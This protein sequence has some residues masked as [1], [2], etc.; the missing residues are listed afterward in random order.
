MTINI[1]L[2]IEDLFIIQIRFF[3]DFLWRIFLTAFSFIDI[4][5]VTFFQFFQLI[6]LVDNVIR[7]GIF[8]KP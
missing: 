3:E 2:L 5:L 7:Y 6:I 1:E 4:S 8:L